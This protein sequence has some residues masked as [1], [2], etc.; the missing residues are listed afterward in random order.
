MV[1]DPDGDTLSYDV[2]AG[3]EGLQVHSTLGAVAWTPFREPAG[4]HSVV[5]RAT[6]EFGNVTLRP[7]TITGDD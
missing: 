3:P 1:L 2:L 7:F 4:T 5:L 6:D